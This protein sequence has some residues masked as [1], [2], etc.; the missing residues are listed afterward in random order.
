MEALASTQLVELP[1][2]EAISNGLKLDLPIL[3]SD[4]SAKLVDLRAKLALVHEVE[5]LSG[6]RRDDFKNEIVQSRQYVQDTQ[7]FLMKNEYIADLY[8]PGGL[9]GAIKSSIKRAA[10]LRGDSGRV[11]PILFDESTVKV[12]IYISTSEL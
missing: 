5:Q 4:A 9:T 8:R 3:P 12:S 7:S 11:G 10:K 6:P 1:E 2:V